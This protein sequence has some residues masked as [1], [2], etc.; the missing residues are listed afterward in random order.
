MADNLR[1][2]SPVAFAALVRKGSPSG[3]CLVRALA[4]VT[5]EKAVDDSRTLEFVISSGGVDRVGDTIA[6]DG[7]KLDA[8]R[9][10]PVVLWAHDGATLPVARATAV[11][12][13]NKTLR[14]RAEFTSPE[15][16]ALGDK[17]YRMYRDGFLNAVSVGFMPLKYAW[18]DT[19]E[20]FGLDFIE[21]ELLEFSAVSVP[22]NA[23]A[24]VE[25]EAPPIVGSAPAELL[26]PPPPKSAPPTVTLARRRLELERLR[27]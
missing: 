7:W 27:F 4:P 16:N 19:P 13:E 23:E 5:I 26:Q 21:Q 20:R 17:V 14:A 6:P 10:N 22:A 25:R 12:T 9:K 8:Y 18:V 15:L 2:I 3:P 1:A 11:W 24:L